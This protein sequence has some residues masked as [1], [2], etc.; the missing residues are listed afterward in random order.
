METKLFLGF[1]VPCGGR[2]RIK[3][4]GSY[5]VRVYISRE[6][7][8]LL[9]EKD[10]KR[11]AIGFCNEL[12]GHLLIATAKDCQCRG[13]KCPDSSDEQL[14]FQ[15]MTD[16]LFIRHLF[17]DDSINEFNPKN[18]FVHVKSTGQKAIA[19]EWP[20][21]NKYLLASGNG[22]LGCDES[23][24]DSYNPISG[25]STFDQSNV[26]SEEN[27]VDEVETTFPTAIDDQPTLVESDLQAEFDEEGSEVAERIL[28][29]SN[30]DSN[31]YALSL[32]DFGEFD[33]EILK[34][35]AP[36]DAQKQAHV[37]NKAAIHGTDEDRLDQGIAG[38]V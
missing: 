12:P 30:K 15:I 20:G 6:W 16:P 5:Y 28:G 3:R 35:K 32:D 27:P 31:R 38:I 7:Y 22:P 24:K 18:I 1:A 21:C 14:S 10:R 11:L 2:T 8:K 36:D 37:D 34:M 29:L 4:V 19:L 33:S 25:D 26:D 17:P 23:R 9:D 13:V